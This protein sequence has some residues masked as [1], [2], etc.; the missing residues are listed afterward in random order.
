MNKK[1]II[2]ASDNVRQIYPQAASSEGYDRLKKNNDPNHESITRM[3]Y[4]YPQI[5]NRIH[6]LKEDLVRMQKELL[7]HK[8]GIEELNNPGADGIK[9]SHK[10]ILQYMLEALEYS[11]ELK[12]KY[13]ADLE[14]KKQKI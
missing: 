1:R 10:Q 7:H 8:L 13:A 6:S 5:N 2:T 12:K 3:L 14:S 4:L 11:I 9:D